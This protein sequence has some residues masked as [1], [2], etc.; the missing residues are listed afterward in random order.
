MHRSDPKLATLHVCTIQPPIG[1][2]PSSHIASAGESE[3][4]QPASG[5]K[6]QALWV[7]RCLSAAITQPG[8]QPGDFTTS[9]RTMSVSSR[10][11]RHAQTVAASESHEGSID[12]IIGPMFSGKTSELVKRVRR[13]MAASKKCL[14]IKYKGDTRYGLE[15]M[16]STHDNVHMD[17]KSVL[18][19]GE[20][21]NAA[22]HYDV[23][24]I[25]EGQFFPGKT[26]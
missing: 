17:A 23:I 18:T 6:S 8:E 12:M 10:S 5:C 22:W 19:L 1:Q 14:L 26:H 4:Q 15:P 13:S 25:D 7:T 11:R 16:L 2:P 21:E 24:A 9:T 3:R 20:M